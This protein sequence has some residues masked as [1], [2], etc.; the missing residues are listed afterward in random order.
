MAKVSAELA[1]SLLANGDEEAVGKA[2][3]LAQ[4]L[5]IA[6]VAQTLYEGISEY[7]PERCDVFL[8]RWL[9][10]L[11]PMEAL[12]AARLTSDLYL[13]GLVHLP[14]AGDRSYERVLKYGARAAMSLREAVSTFVGLGDNPDFS[15]D[16]S[17]FMHAA[18]QV[19]GKLGNIAV[20]LDNVAADVRERMAAQ[21]S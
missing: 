9:E 17:E 15:F 14:D 16:E 10:E 8:E 19:S 1:E 12:E 7:E 5:S 4:S 21:D 13:L 6:T 20:I 2:L 11:T 3:D 18:E